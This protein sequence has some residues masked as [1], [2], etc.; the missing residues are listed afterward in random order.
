MFRRF[1]AL[2]SCLVVCVALQSCTLAPKRVAIMDFENA[3]GDHRLD[4]LS[5]AIPESLITVMNRDPRRVYILERQ[6]INRYLAEIDRAPLRPGERLSNSRFQ[7]LG[8]RLGADYLV[9]G[10]VSRFGKMYVVQCRLFSVARGEL[11]PSAS[12]AQQCNQEEEVVIIVQNLGR[13][14]VKQVSARSVQ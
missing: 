11:V 5:T 9:V 14:M 2:P 12:M 7:Q 10:S 8:K 13:E 3:T 4:G 1:V 6:D